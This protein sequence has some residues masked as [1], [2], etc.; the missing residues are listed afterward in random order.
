MVR[1]RCWPTRA[2]FSRS[3]PEG[4]LCCPGWAGAM[5]PG[6]RAPPWSTVPPGF[7]NFGG[8]LAGYFAGALGGTHLGTPLGAVLAAGFTLTDGSDAGLPLLSDCSDF[9]SLLLTTLCF[10]AV[11]AVLLVELVVSPE[12]ADPGDWLASVADLALE[13][14]VSSVRL[15]VASRS[16]SSGGGEPGGV[17]G[18]PPLPRLP[19]PCHPSLLSL[20]F[21][22][23]SLSR[24]EASPPPYLGVRT[25][26][27]PWGGDRSFR[28][29]SLSADEGCCGRPLWCRPH[30]FSSRVH[31]VDRFR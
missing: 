16:T 24:I 23:L 6:G 27:V 20:S 11:D 7:A 21:A 14:R 28:V 10:G 19:G 3:A 25:L 13:R 12:L 4:G 1:D 22:S 26:M 29:P 8:G 31:Q 2:S 5:L 30:R 17:L 9:C 15:R 18:L